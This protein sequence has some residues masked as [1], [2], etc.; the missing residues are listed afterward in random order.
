MAFPAPLYGK[1]TRREKN[2]IPAEENTL[3]KKSK[4]SYQAVQY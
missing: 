2:R 1:E 3:F 4:C